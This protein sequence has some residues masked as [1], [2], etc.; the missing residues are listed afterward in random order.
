[1][2]G[3]LRRTVDFVQKMWLNREEVRYVFIG[4]LTTLVNFSLFVLICIIMGIDVSAGNMTSISDAVLSSGEIPVSTSILFA[5]VASISASIVFA[6]FANKLV[7]FKQRCSTKNEL[8]LEFVKFIGSRLFTMAIEIGAV[9][10]FV[11]LL[12]MNV[13]I[14]K[15]VSQVIVIILNYIISKLIV[16][17]AAKQ[18]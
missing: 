7:V 8:A 17:R 2:R 1:M 3:V 5:N 4:G 9:W 14:G 11:D 18:R 10:L 16:F 12:V 13:L 15:A 6:Y